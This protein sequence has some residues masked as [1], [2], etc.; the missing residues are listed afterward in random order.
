MRKSSLSKVQKN[1]KVFNDVNEHENRYAQLT[2]EDSIAESSEGEKV[3]SNEDDYDPTSLDISNKNTEPTEKDTL[4]TNAL[5]NNEDF[6]G[7]DFDSS[8]DND[9]YEKSDEEV[10][11][12]E[13]KDDSSSTGK[14]V[15][16]SDY[17]WILNHDHSKQKEIADWLCLEIKDFVAYISPSRSEI[18]I[19]NKTISKIRQAVKEFWP[20]ADLHIFGSYATDLYLPGSDIDC[21]VN[22]KAGG[23]ESRSNLY[24]LASFLKR[25][26]LAI[27]VEVIAKARVPIIK[28]VEPESNIHIDVSFERLNGLEAAK[29]IRDWLTETPGLRELVLIVKQFLSARRLNNVHNG[30][31]GGFS[32][33]C[34]VYSFLQLHPRILTDDIDPMN[35]LGVLLIDFFEL[36]GKNF[37]YDDIGI[38][39]T[40]GNVRYLKKSQHPDLTMGSRSSFTLCIQDPGDAKNNIS[41]GSFNIRDIKKAFAGAYDLL[42]D[43]CYELYY[44][45]YKE[46]VG[47][48]ILGNVIK[49]RGKLREF[50]DER[51]LVTNKAIVENENYHKRK[52]DMVNGEDSY[53]RDEDIF[54]I[55]T[56]DEEHE[57]YKITE[58]K[59]YD[60]E[61]QDMSKIDKSKEEKKKRNKPANDKRKK[62]KI[63]HDKKKEE[64]GEKKKKDV[65]KEISKKSVDDYM[66]LNDNSNEEADDEYNPELVDI[67]TTSETKEPAFEFKDGDK[68]QSDAYDVEND[69]SYSP[70]IIEPK[71]NKQRKRD[72]WLSKGNSL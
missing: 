47:K 55:G 23:K 57:K 61:R 28:F 10:N 45:T 15:F 21:V 2:L 11:F 51:N 56:S 17:P 54:V 26:K 50:R 68:I 31:L 36:Y 37:A 38:S 41:R 46:R 20:D 3:S 43:R 70:S 9:E 6:I 16:N 64:S 59:S 69:S 7:F 42:T 22:S 24:S 19:R 33:I 27:Q 65:I 13:D 62:Q 52:R 48:S 39:V 40:D 44:A 49:Y 32:I 63:K 71:L 30:G 58:D 60:E 67:S 18:K 53:E 8:S 35:N 25:K 34:L 12:E 14:H 1:F 4:S 29:I 66:G 5:D 72:Y